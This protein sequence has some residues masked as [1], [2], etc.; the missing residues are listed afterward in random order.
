[1][2]NE[3]ASRHVLQTPRI[4]LR[5]VAYGDGELTSDRFPCGYRAQACFVDYRA[6]LGFNI[7]SLRTGLCSETSST[8]MPTPAVA[9]KSG[10]LMLI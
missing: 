7:F 3:L 10:H 1:M 9:S 6:G 4:G 8:S 2:K 5:H